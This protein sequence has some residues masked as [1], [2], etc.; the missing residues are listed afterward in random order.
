MSSILSQ[1]AT[2]K[3]LPHVLHVVSAPTSFTCAR[4]MKRIHGSALSTLKGTA[5]VSEQW[6]E[7]ASAKA[8]MK[9]FQVPQDSEASVLVV[10][11]PYTVFL[12]TV[13]GLAAC[14]EDTTVVRIAALSD[15]WW[16]TVWTDIFA[17]ERHLV[18]T[19]Y[20]TMIESGSL[21]GTYTYASQA[22][23]QALQMRPVAMPRP[24]CSPLT[25]TVTKWGLNTSLEP[26]APCPTTS[27]W[28]AAFM[29]WQS[30]SVDPTPRY[31]MRPNSQWSGVQ[32]HPTVLTRS[33]T[34][35]HQSV[36]SHSG[37]SQDIPIPGGV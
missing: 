4:P 24:W 18:F 27:R 16:K 2:W 14:L 5:S 19:L 33:A 37:Q 13:R 32:A 36:G 20:T 23:S 29:R 15:G 17:G 12:H 3:D 7:S 35:G 11:N 28:H 9:R 22:R 30:H 21:T 26:V 25:T 31:E 8:A 6:Y 10:V 1:E 34:T